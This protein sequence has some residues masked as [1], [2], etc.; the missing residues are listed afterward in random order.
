MSLIL[1]TKNKIVIAILFFF[2][3]VLQ[4]Q[5][6]DDLTND[7]QDSIRA[8]TTQRYAIFTI[9]GFAPIKRNNSTYQNGTDITFGFDFGAQLFVYDR[10]FIGGHI[11]TNKAEVTNKTLVGEYDKTKITLFYLELGYEFEFNKK[12]NLGVSSSPLGKAN[13]NN[14]ITN[15]SNLK[16]QTDIANVILFNT[17]LRYNFSQNFSLFASYSFRND[18]LKIVAAPEIQNSFDNIQYHNFGFGLKYAVGLR[19]MFKR[20]SY[21]RDYDMN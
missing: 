8:N 16:S 15:S 3:M 2:S 21:Y 12:F 20:P 17:Y 9:G 11:N 18:N 19:S 5:D 6:F 1:T 13:Y 7:V 10:F 4:A 14:T